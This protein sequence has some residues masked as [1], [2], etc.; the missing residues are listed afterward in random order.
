MLQTGAC[1]IVERK[2]ETS[3]VHL[4]HIIFGGSVFDSV[5]MSKSGNST[6]MPTVQL[7]RGEKV[8]RVDS[9][10][11][12]SLTWKHFALSEKSMTFGIFFNFK[13]LICVCYVQ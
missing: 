1:W 13:V 7:C 5:Q 11:M 10:I 8:V 3:Y 12:I 9:E 2:S 6:T 4:F